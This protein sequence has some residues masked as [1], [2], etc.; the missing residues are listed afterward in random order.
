MHVGGL[1]RLVAQA[2]ALPGAG[3]AAVAGVSEAGDPTVVSVEKAPSGWP[4][5]ADRGV[6]PDEIEAPS[7]S[8]LRRGIG[9]L[10]QQ[11]GTAIEEALP[12]TLALAA[13]AWDQADTLAVL[14][15]ALVAEA[16]TLRMQAR[17][18]AAAEEATRRAEGIA[19][20]L[21]LD[22]AVGLASLLERRLATLVRLR[23]RAPGAD[24]LPDGRPF[25]D[26]GAAITEAAR[27]WL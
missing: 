1:D 16:R 2:R 24:L 11:L 12:R 4:R 25:L 19:A 17:A 6:A 13:S 8:E 22:A 21:T 20:E 7:P 23:L 27:A 26:V 10:L 14:D 3:R 15:R 18:L 5:A 9:A